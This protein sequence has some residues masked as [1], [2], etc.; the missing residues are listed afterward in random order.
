MTSTDQP[1]TIIYI[2]LGSN[3][4]DRLANLRAALARL[5]AVVTLTAVSPIYETDPVGYLD[6]GP[7]LNA[8][9]SGATAATPQALLA[10]LLRIERDLG[11]ERTFPNAPRPID[12][13]L[14]FYDALCLA[15]PNLTVPHPRLHERFFVLVP[16][17]DIAPDF[18]HPQLGRTVRQLL[19]DLG[20]P[21]GIHRLPDCP[22]G[23]RPS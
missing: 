13:D 7:F 19:A 20:P 15:T 14:L 4:G 23:H 16:L 6:Q 22:T 5:R 1:A 21:Q 18:R 17:S 11:R 8:V 3:L 9:V 12:L 10:A 2:A